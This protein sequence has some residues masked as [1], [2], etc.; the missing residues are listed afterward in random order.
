MRR[1]LRTVFITTAI[2][3]LA[4]GLLLAGISAY[5]GVHQSGRAD[6][7]CVFGAAVWG[8][9]PSP[10]LEARVLWA[11]QLYQ[12]RR[13][14]TLFLS[15]GPTGS[16]LTEPDV[17]EK[18]AEAHGVPRSA[19]VLDS[20]GISTA[21]TVADL[22]RYMAGNNMKTCLMVSSPFH[23]ARI[24]ILARLKGLQALADPPLQTPITQL[25]W[26]NLT[27]IVREALALVKDLIV[28]AV[29]PG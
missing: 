28:F 8:D 15:G 11:V 14:G 4:F 22:E 16:N 18:V 19:I 7:I 27:S 10:E 13:A 21:A 26:Q 6:I 2:V 12:E 17:M 24:M 29:S 1:F 20:T 3:C 9:K 25:P 5:G 23:M